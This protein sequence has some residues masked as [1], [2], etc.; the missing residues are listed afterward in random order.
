MV[1]ARTRTLLL[2]KDPTASRRWGVGVVVL[3]VLSLGYFAALNAFTGF[4]WSV[5]Q[6]LWWEGYAG[7]LGVLITAQAY[8]NDGLLLSWALAF[9][10]ILGVVLNY[11][12]IAMTGRPPGLLTLVAL[13]LIGG[14]LGAAI[15]GTPAFTIGATTR[16]LTTKTGSTDR[17]R[18]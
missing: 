5:H 13:A 6:F 14:L 10:G 12:G 3:F 9:A 18:R 16:R 4:G 15:L 2:G 7:L 11:G 17:D 8:A 1:S